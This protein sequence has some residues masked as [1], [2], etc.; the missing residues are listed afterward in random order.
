M[1]LPIPSIDL[2]RGRPCRLFQGDPA[3]ATF[4]DADPLGRAQT[5]VGLG[6]QLFHLV[7]L[8]GALE[9][10]AAAENQQL[11][12]QI[13][14]DLSIS[15]QMGG[16][17]RSAQDVERALNMGL[18]RVILGTAALDPDQG[19]RRLLSDSAVNRRLIADIGFVDD[20]VLVKGW[21]TG[22]GLTVHDA[23]RR[24]SDA[25]FQSLIATNKKRDGASTGPD[26]QT[27]RSIATSFS[28]LSI[29][30]SGGVSTE[31]D[32]D[33]IASIDLPNIAGFIMGRRLWAED[34]LEFFAAAM[35][36]F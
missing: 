27:I 34:G 3:Q 17:I 2:L 36:R 6:A 11:I 7:N 5:F 19:L 12:V 1:I 28:L 14:Q 24:I 31:D 9:G 10:P 8:D 4:Y 26:L 16:G 25:G 22:T 23:V 35:R 13:A 30:I 33:A 32:L 20:Q 18:D 21:Q 29:I 15:V